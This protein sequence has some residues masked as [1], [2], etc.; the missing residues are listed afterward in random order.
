MPS[1]KEDV[2]KAP[3]TN[4]V[5]NVFGPLNSVLLGS[6]CQIYRKSA[7]AHVLNWIIIMAVVLCEMYHVVLVNGPRLKLDKEFLSNVM[8]P[9][10]Y[11][12]GII[13]MVVVNQNRS[14][15]RKIL[16]TVTQDLDYHR[17]KRLHRFALKGSLVSFALV[18]NFY[19]CYFV[20]GW[21]HKEGS[22]YFMDWTLRLTAC[23]FLSHNWVV[24]GIHVYNFFVRAIT[25]YELMY[26][27]KLV[28]QMQANR[29]RPTPNQVCLERLKVMAMKETFVRVTGIIPVLWFLKEFIYLSGILMNLKATFSNQ[30]YFM[31][32]IMTHV[33]PLTLI[34]STVISLMLF[35]DNCVT[36]LSTK[37]E[38][39]K[40]VILEK[41]EASNWFPVLSQLDSEKHFQ[42]RAWNLFDVNKY[43]ILSFVASLITFSALFIQISDSM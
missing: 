13:F 30:G 41:E 7:W 4:A 40:R 26:F 3:E 8:Y 22:P 16:D 33:I 10:F 31:M 11:A 19:F 5:G 15:L 36:E 42:F 2:E 35:T 38:E 9:V 20:M 1:K 12:S 23:V 6:G 18:I 43:L 27:D 25:E 37:I 28:W 21:I 14:T 29:F 24:G 39:V 32:S 34:I 17:Q